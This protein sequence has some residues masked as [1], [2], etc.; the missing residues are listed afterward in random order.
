MFNKNHRLSD[1]G[2]DYATNINTSAALPAPIDIA[3]AQA[4]ELVTEFYR[5]F[6]NVSDLIPQQKEIAQASRLISTHGMEKARHVV[7][8]S[9]QI[10]PSTKYEP[11]IFGGILQ[12]EGRAIADY[13]KHQRNRQINTATERCTFC[14]RVGMV[15]MKDAKGLPISVRCS[16]NVER[17]KAYAESKGYELEVRNRAH[18]VSYEA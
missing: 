3:D 11:Q 2:V 4:R 17:M 8:Y 7:N 16:H 6:H 1:K 14:D 15:G 5:K 10:A 18:N 12:Y 9:H 13:N